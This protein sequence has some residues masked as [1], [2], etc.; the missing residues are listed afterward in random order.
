M[1]VVRGSAKKV[2][3]SPSPFGSW[4]SRASSSGFVVQYAGQ[5]KIRKIW[6]TGRNDELLPAA[7]PGMIDRS[8]DISPDG[9]D[10]VYVAP[11]LSSRLILV[12]NLFK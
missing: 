5:N 12:E 11:R 9:N 1:P 2:S 8:I 7:F 4:T 10:L 6:F 3:S